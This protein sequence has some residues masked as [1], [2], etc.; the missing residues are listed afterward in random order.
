MQ[1]LT[2]KILSCSKCEG[3]NCLANKTLSSPGYGNPKS[4]VIFYGSSVGGSGMTRV[5]PFASGSGKI[6]D[7]ILK[8]AEVKK[9]DI[10][11]S[12]IVKCRLPNLRSPKESELKNCEDFAREEIKIIKPDIIVP[13]GSIATKL[14]LGKSVTLSKVVYQEFEVQGVKVIPM[15][16][17]AYIMRGIGDKEKYFN[18]MIELCKY[19]NG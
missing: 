2:D 9:D 5:I 4:K 1:N 19:A 16:H 13:M 6:I 10:Y 8:Q 15:Y 7:K 11:I 3:L 17:P 18:K 12:N 14:L